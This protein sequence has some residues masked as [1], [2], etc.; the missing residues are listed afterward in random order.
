VCRP[1]I[2]INSIALLAY[3]ADFNRLEVARIGNDKDHPPVVV[4]ARL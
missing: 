1:D 2:S 4:L 3:G